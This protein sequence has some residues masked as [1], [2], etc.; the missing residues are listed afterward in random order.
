MNKFIFS[1]FFFF[2]STCLALDCNLELRAIKIS[3]HSLGQEFT[4]VK[5]LVTKI[6]T[7]TL[8]HMGNKSTVNLQHKDMYLKL[9]NQIDEIIKKNSCQISAEKL[10]VIFPNH[11]YSYSIQ[12]SKLNDLRKLKS[13][14]PSWEEKVLSLSNGSILSNK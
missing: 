6:Q 13:V 14:K 7:I 10:F 2:V 5:K 3:G 1:V 9:M 11:S 8:V 4:M 12:I